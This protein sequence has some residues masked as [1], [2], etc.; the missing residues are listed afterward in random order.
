MSPVIFLILVLAAALI[1]FATMSGLKP[2]G[3][4][5]SSRPSGHARGS[6]QTMTRDQIY[7][8]W[9][10][11]EAMSAG[12]GNGLR[13]AINEA[14]KLLD[15]VLRQQGAHGDSMADRM[16]S[17]NSRFSQRDDVWRAHKVRNALAHEVGFDLVPSQAKEAI[18]SFHQALLDLGAL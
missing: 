18:A 6:V 12:G 5:R 17:F 2:K 10:T 11:I 4:R 1:L 14:D 3:R 9:Q 13:Q 16:R 15:H 8:R 7:T